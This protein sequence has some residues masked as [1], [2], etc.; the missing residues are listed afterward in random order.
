MAQEPK[1]YAH[2]PKLDSIKLAKILGLA[3][4][5]ISACALPSGPTPYPSP[6]VVYTIAAQTIEA[7]FTLSAP[8]P[9]NTLAPQQ[10][11]ETPVPADT[12]QIPAGSPTP[13]PAGTNT[14]TLVP[15]TSTIPMITATINTNCRAGAR[16]YFQA[17]SYLLVGTWVEVR[18]RSADGYWWY[19]QNPSNLSTSCWVWTQTTVVYGNTSGIPIVQ[20][21]PIPTLYPTPIPPSPIPIPTQVTSFIATF[22]N[23][24][25]C[26]GVPHASFKLQNN[27]TATFKSMNLTVIDLDTALT[28]SATI[29][30]VP[31][32]GSGG[33]CP[34]GGYTLNPGGVRYVAGSLGSPA[35]SGHRARGTILLCTQDAQKGV[36]LVKTAD[37]TVP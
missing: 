5:V 16:I 20:S 22:D 27:G 23:V 37:F 18:G 7:Q 19:I 2:R 33:D 26:G 29:S 1:S 9:T 21:P 13:M 12:E 32:M 36:C 11:T 24:H 3:L 17:V 14:A 6:D 15:P 30:D 35:P 8:P 4:L 10:P 31:F 34:I 28:L 25:N